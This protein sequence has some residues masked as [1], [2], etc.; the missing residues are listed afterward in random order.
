MQRFD[1]KQGCIVAMTTPFINGAV[2]W[3][4]VVKNTEFLISQKVA[5]VA[6][7]GTTGESP[8]LSEREHLM[9]F[10]VVAK[11]IGKRKCFK[12]AGSGSNSTRE[13]LDYLEAAAV[14]GYNGGLLVDC[15]YNGPSS[16]ELRDGYYRRAVQLA[17]ERYP[18]LVICPY[19]IPGRSG[20]ALSEVDLAKLAWEKGS[21]VAM[22]KDAT[23]DFERMRRTREITPEGFLIFSGDDNITFDILTDPE[24]RA[25][26][27]VSVMGNIVGG[28]IQQMCEK[29]FTGKLEEAK[30]IKEALDPLFGLVTVK[31]TRIEI[32][33][34]KEGGSMAY[35]VEDKFRNPDAIKTIMA[36]LGMPSGLGRDPL[37]KMTASAVGKVRTT[38]WEVWNENPWLLEPIQ[39]FYGVKIEERLEKDEVWAE[40]TRQGGD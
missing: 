11:T 30:R 10:G 8:V 39:D 18:H 21:N 5:G 3:P 15:Y 26:G 34:T 29:I 36:V 6:P 37:Y 27:V 9:L 16:L 19:V 14:F 17:A 13:M 7:S 12:L 24:I 20:C 4:G 23:L 32:L 1:I 22:V 25:N 38:L 35:S 31:A 40:L 2:D 33:P 28:P